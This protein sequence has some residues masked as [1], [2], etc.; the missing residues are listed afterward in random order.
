M[1]DWLGRLSPAAFVAL[2]AVTLI[3]IA[4]AVFLLFGLL[5]NLSGWRNINL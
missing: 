2:L 3:G 5:D 1:K 4:L